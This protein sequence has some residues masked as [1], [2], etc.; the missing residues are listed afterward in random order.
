MYRPKRLMLGWAGLT[1]TKLELAKHL[2]TLQLSL[3]FMTALRAR[4]KIPPARNAMM[5][6]FNEIA[7][8]ELTHRP[9]AGTKIRPNPKIGASGRL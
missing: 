8:G 5:G 1:V 4:K 2:V 7:K 9:R 6:K 3:N